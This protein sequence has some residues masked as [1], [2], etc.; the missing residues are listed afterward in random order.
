MTKHVTT[1]GGHRATG[2]AADRRAS[3]G[4]ATSAKSQRTREELLSAA[5][6][7]FTRFGYAET[8]VERIVAEAG[9]A[10]GSFYT[11]FE[12]KVDLFS[13]LVDTIEHAISAQVATLTATKRGDAFENLL[14]SNRNYL[15]V[16]AE[17]ADLYRL[18][19][20]MSA[21]DPDVQKNRLK[22]RQRH[23]ARV[24]DTIRRWQRTSRASKGIDAE[25]TAAALVSMLSGFA[26]WMHVGGD[27]Y[28]E[29]TAATRLTEIW[30]AACGL[31]TSARTT[32]EGS[33]R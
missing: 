33:K 7:C 29:D 20:E 3:T 12:S 30:A 15:R 4:A 10:R 2:T 1:R 23:V 31:A 16:V 32:P 13:H 24:A 17:N 11:Y 5:R 8:T 26:Q 27:S 21:H 14:Q 18:V 28:D 9:L 25:V 6:K 19:D 22:S